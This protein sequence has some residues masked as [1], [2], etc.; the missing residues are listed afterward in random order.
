MKKLKKYVVLTKTGKHIM[1]D[2]TNWGL[3][4]VKKS[5]DW[6]KESIKTDK[7]TLYKGEKALYNVYASKLCGCARKCE[8]SPG[9]TEQD[10]C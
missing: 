10:N 7:I 2:L 9:I 6:Y 5:S 8:E 3:F 4:F 1:E